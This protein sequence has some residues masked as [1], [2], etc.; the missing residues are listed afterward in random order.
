MIPARYT[1]L[2]EKHTCAFHKV[3]PLRAHIYL[4][5]PQRP[6]PSTGRFA[7]SDGST[8]CS[9]QESLGNGQ[10]PAERLSCLL[11]HDVPLGELAGMAHLHSLEPP[12]TM[13]WGVE[14]R[15][16]QDRQ[17]GGHFL[18]KGTHVMPGLPARHHILRRALVEVITSCRTAPHNQPVAWRQWLA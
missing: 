1:L 18:C 6:V 13:A 4:P 14:R 12:G 7:V 10:G 2:R 17:G 15:Y 5:W 11:R 3:K 9:H 16:Q 8:H